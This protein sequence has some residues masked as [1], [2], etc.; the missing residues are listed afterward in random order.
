MVVEELILRLLPYVSLAWASN[1][2]TRT[3][4]VTAQTLRTK[5]AVFLGLAALAQRQY[6][7]FLRSIHQGTRLREGG[8]VERLGC[9][10]RFIGV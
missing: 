2:S 8:D 9:V 3:E 6:V 1:S 7:G 4:T 10:V 5:A